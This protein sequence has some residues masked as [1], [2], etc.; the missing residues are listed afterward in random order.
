[1]HEYAYT[2]WGE[3]RVSR[4]N[5][6]FVDLQRSCCLC[7]STNLNAVVGKIEMSDV[8]RDLSQGAVGHNLNYLAT[9]I[10]TGCP[11]KLS[12]SLIPNS[13]NNCYY[14]DAEDRY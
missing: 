12:V 5:G 2:K 6:T 11:Q 7:I 9:F 4:G 1:M 3:S 10:S 13:V 8:L 14:D